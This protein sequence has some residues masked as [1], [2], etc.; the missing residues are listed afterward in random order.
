MNAPALVIL[1]AGMGS[2]YGGLKQIDPIDE[3]GHKIIDFSIYDAMHAGFEK[4]VFIIKKEHENDFRECIG[5]AVSKHIAVEYVFQDMLDVPAD[6]QIPEERVKPWGTT[7]A[8]LCCKE[9]LNQPFA[10]INADDY[11]GKSA[12][13]TLYDYL[14]AHADDTE[15]NYAMVGYELGKTLTK[16]G[17][18]ARGCCVINDHGFLTTIKERS[19]I[20][21]TE[22]GA[23]YTE[24]DG[25]TYVPVSVDTLVSMNMWGFYPSVLEEFEKAMHLFFKEAVAKNP[26][27][28]ECLIPVEMD[29]LLKNG[30]ASVEVLS[31]SDR[32]FGVTYQEDKPVV[33]ASIKELKE[34]GVYPE[35]LW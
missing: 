35:K 24:D 26:L 9:V 3:Q 10:V 4:V 2:R 12:Y 22:T 31:S 25:E 6:F 15:N 13:K 14:M 1:A 34:K 29:V 16:T 20:I 23:A 28:A 27:K 21:Q 17:S 7:H 33:M 5:N 11:Y 30:K 19:K 32:W 8:L 18:V